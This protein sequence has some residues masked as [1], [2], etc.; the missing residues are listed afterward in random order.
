M[1]PFFMIVI[2]KR[3]DD[4]PQMP[5]AEWDDAIQTLDSDGPDKSLGIRVQV[6]TPGWQKQRLYATAPQQVPGRRAPRNVAQSGNQR[7]NWQ[8]EDRKSVV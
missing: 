8:F 1:R 3:S 6:W 5:L 4:G 7:D 2:D